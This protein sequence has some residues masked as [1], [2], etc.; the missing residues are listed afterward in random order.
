MSDDERG[1]GG[2]LASARRL[3][4]SLLGLIQARVELFAVELQEEKL[5]A[6]NLLGWLALAVA[7]AIAGILVAV[8]TVGLFL[9]RA[10]GYAG[11]AGLAVA[12]LG[13]AALV[14]ALVRRR[15]TQA[16]GPFAGTVEEFR[17]D[18]ACLRRDR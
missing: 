13:S 10:A 12:A 7:L 1:A 17:K 6:I 16:P 18:M 4:R 9:W 2:I 14:F 8:A 5:R 11:L 3:G 15:L